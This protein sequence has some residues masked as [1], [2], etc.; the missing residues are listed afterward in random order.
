MIRNLRRAGV[1]VVKRRGK[2]GH[3]LVRFEGKQTTVPMHGDTDLGP[4]FIRTICK[5]LG[6]DPGEVL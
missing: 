4:E 6:L 5:Q 1:D 3:W 2:G